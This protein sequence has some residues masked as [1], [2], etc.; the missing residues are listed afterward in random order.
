MIPCLVC[1]RDCN[2]SEEWRRN[3]TLWRR[4]VCSWK[5]LRKYRKHEDIYIKYWTEGKS[6][7][8]IRELVKRKEMESS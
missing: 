6:I 2:Q 7:E 1:G 8:E 3:K 5:C 4:R